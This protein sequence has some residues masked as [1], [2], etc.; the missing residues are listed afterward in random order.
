MG[1]ETVL[2]AVGH[3]DEER[4]DPLG[5]TAVDIAGPAGAT[6]A[7]AH[8]FTKSEYEETRSKLDFDASSEVTPDAV[9]KRYVTIREL[10]DTMSAADVEYTWHGRLSDDEASRG[11]VVVDLAEE[12]DAD[13][14]VVGGRKRSPAGKAVFGSTAQEIMLESPCP[15]TFVRGE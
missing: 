11:E 15:V 4:I 12:L 1:L 8:V 9:A 13:L 6:V 3:S 2:L 10:G 14:V 5:A 7:L